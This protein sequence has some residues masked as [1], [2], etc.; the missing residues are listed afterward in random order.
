[1]K[2]S[3]HSRRRAAQETESK[4]GRAGNRLLFVLPKHHGPCILSSRF[5]KATVAHPRFLKVM[6]TLAL[7]TSRETL[8]TLLEKEILNCVCFVRK[9]YTNSIGARLP[10]K[11]LHLSWK[12]IPCVSQFRRRRKLSLFIYFFAPTLLSV[13]IV[14][15]IFK[16]GWLESGRNT[17]LRIRLDIFL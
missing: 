16:S 2:S 15:I 17:I 13:Q 14:K 5:Q 10:H 7:Y 11:R 6:I 1:M 12:L 8:C 9:Y 3:S 4:P